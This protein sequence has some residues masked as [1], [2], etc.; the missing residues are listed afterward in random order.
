MLSVSEE[1]E[2]LGKGKVISV[3]TA[4]GSN[5]LKKGCVGRGASAFKHDN[6]SQ[7][8]S[9]GRALKRIN[10]DIPF[11]PLTLKQNVFKM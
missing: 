2:A 10:S 1:D 3:V 6:L 8:S 4:K 7:I 11:S 5:A 9:V